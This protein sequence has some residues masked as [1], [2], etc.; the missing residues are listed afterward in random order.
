MA[1]LVELLL[2]KQAVAGSNPAVRSSNRSVAKSGKARALDARNSWVR[3]P[4]LRL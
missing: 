4:L 3:I 1:Q 2:P